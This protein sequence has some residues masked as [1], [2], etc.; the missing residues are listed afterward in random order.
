MKVNSKNLMLKSVLLAACLGI[1][2]SLPGQTSQTQSQPQQNRSRQAQAS[3]APASQV[4]QPAPPSDD[5]VIGAEDVISISVWKEPDLTRTVP[6][7][8][9]GKISLPLI[10][11]VMASGLTPPKLSSVISEKLKAYIS[12]PEVNVIVEQVKSPVFNI[13]G[14]VLKPGPYELTRPTTILD[15]IGLAG[16]PAAFAKLKNIHVMRTLP[17]GRQQ[18]LYF[19]YKAALKGQ[20]MEQN[21]YLKPGDILIVP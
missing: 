11:E 4:A 8:P 10:G 7:R 13:I 3:R 1:A 19:D 18:K 6:V 17:D 21:I 14:Q 2:A 15:A 5:Y 9:D 20:K 16:G 12:N